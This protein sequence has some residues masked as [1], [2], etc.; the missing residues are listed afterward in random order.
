[1]QACLVALLFLLLPPQLAGQTVSK[2]LVI[3]TKENRAAFAN[4]RLPITCVI[5]LTTGQRWDAPCNWTSKNTNIVSVVSPARVTT[6]T[7]KGANGFTWVVGAK[8][9]KRDSV[10]IVRTANITRTEFRPA[11][12][13]LQ[14]GK[15][16]QFCHLFRT[17]EGQ[18][19]VDD[20]QA[21]IPACIT[22]L[23][24]WRLTH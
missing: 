10:Q 22:L 6:A 7:Y 8:Q 2:V 9:G 16:K 17:A 3:I 5:T 1:M 15:T 21:H 18:W 24:N 23:N 20:L 14:I 11:M 12:V 19:W 13:S 4:N